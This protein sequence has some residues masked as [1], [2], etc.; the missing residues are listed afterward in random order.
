MSLS[1]KT[2]F[3]TGASRGIGKAIAIRAARDGANVVIASKSEKPHPKLTGT[4]HTAAEEIRDAGGKC[5][6]L[7]LDV[8]DD[9]RIAECVAAAVAHFGGID[10][11][12]NNA[13]AIQLTGTTATA[14]KRFDL[15]MA[16]NVRGTFA[17][18]QACI[19][20]LLQADNPKILNISPPLG[21]ETRWFQNHVAYTM[22]K[23]GMSMCVLGMAGEFEGKIAVNALWPRTTIATA[24]VNMVG[25]SQLM[26]SS[27]KP[28]IMAD[29][30]HWILTQGAEVTGT[31]FVDDDVLA[32]A[33]VQDLAHYSVVPG[34]TLTP[35]YF[36]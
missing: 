24:A 18:S 8:R 21:M 7:V 33:G 5:L 9:E 22:S 25:G 27:R 15:M 32:L 31:F 3:I 23:F 10:I 17:T 4:I 13:S 6:P 26:A 28:E 14:M 1:G 11:C 29:A 16:V 19:P 34:A 2:L 30:A 20:H 36:V 35:D 12:V